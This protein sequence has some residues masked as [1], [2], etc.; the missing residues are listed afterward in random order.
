M[1]PIFHDFG[2]HRD[3]SGHCRFCKQSNMENVLPNVDRRLQLM[4]IMSLLIII[5]VI[6]IFWITFAN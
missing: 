4:F 3:I 2:S 5:I 6:F 1:E